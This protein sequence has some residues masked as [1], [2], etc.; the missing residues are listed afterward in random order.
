[1][2][3]V[4]CQHCNAVLSYDADDPLIKRTHPKGG[5]DL[6]KCPV[7]G[8]CTKKI[9]PCGFKDWLPCTTECKYYETCTRNPNWKP[10]NKVKI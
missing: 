1:M 8:R 7:C 6:I 2:S 3:K 9:L 10:R 5:Y 4:I